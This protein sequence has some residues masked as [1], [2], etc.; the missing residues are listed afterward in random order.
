MLRDFKFGETIEKINNKD[1][2]EFFEGDTKVKSARSKTSTSRKS[3]IQSNTVHKLSNT[4]QIH[5]TIIMSPTKLQVPR[6]HVQVIR[7][8]PSPVRIIRSSPMRRSVS[9]YSS[10][11]SIRH[12][13][14]ISRGSELRKSV[15]VSRQSVMVSERDSA[16]RSSA[17]GSVTRIETTVGQPI[18][19]TISTKRIVHPGRVKSITRLNS[20]SSLNQSAV[21][22]P[23]TVRQVKTIIHSGRMRSSNLSMNNSLMLNQNQNHV[24][25]VRR[26]KPQIKEVIF[27]DNKSSRR[28]RVGGM[29]SSLI[30]SRHKFEE[31]NYDSGRQQK[32]IIDARKSIA[33]S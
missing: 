32:R 20:R 25:S 10:P 1:N 33:N 14:V 17:R 22:H 9:R 16:R 23:D 29:K 24:V 30:S 12:S 5:K 15:A 18:K 26:T 11:V 4:P 19:R 2:L 3:L 13:R 21:V 7:H 28:E 27:G 8:S 31:S 6:T